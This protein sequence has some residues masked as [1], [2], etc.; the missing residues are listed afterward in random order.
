MFTEEDRQMMKQILD[1]SKR[2]LVRIQRRQEIY[3]YDEDGPTLVHIPV[4][5]LLK[6]GGYSDSEVAE[7]PADHLIWNTQTL[8]PT[9]VPNPLRPG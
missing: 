6:P 1:R 5:E 9:G 2:V 8:F 4:P 3:N 7:F